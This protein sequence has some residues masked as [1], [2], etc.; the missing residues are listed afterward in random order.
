LSNLL[1]TPSFSLPWLSEPAKPAVPEETER[2]T[3]GAI[4][5]ETLGLH[6]C[7]LEAGHTGPHL[8]ETLLNP[9][10]NAQWFGSGPAVYDTQPNMQPNMIDKILEE[11]G[12]ELAHAVIAWPPMNSAHEGYAVILEETDEL[13]EHVKTGQKKRDLAAMRKEAVQIAAMAVRFA[14]E[15]CDEERGRK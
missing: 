13:W 4:P 6:S 1:S 14:L 11:V 2:Q 12:D 10:I 7:F 8:S 15:V 9:S 5:Q 3:C